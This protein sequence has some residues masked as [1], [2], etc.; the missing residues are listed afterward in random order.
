MTDINEYRKFM[1]DPSNAMKC[2]GCP[3]NE[4]FSDWPETRLPCGQFNCWVTMH[5]QER[6]VS[7]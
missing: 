6:E 5:Q 4:G 7:E 2:D 1:A 3:A